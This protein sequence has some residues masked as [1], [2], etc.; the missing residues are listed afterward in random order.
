MRICAVDEV[1]HAGHSIVRLMGADVCKYCGVDSIGTCLSCSSRV[2]NRH[3]ILSV[4]STPSS[5]AT[6]LTYS[7]F[8]DPPLRLQ[9]PVGES[10]V[11]LTVNPIYI[12]AFTHGPP[13]CESCRTQD[14]ERAAS[15]AQQEASDRKVRATSVAQH[16]KEMLANNPDPEA[17]R[18][19]VAQSRNGLA[20]QVS[21]EFVAELR[22]DLRSAW[23]L[24]AASGLWKP[25]HEHVT[26]ELRLRGFR[27]P[28]IAGNEAR[29]VITGREP[30]WSA[31]SDGHLLSSSGDV[32]RLGQQVTV[33]IPRKRPAALIRRAVIRAGDQFQVSDVW[34]PKDSSVYA[35]G[36]L[37]EGA[38][39]LETAWRHAFWSLAD[40]V[41]VTGEL[42]ERLGPRTGRA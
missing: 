17:L 25:T 10:V 6:R 7:P 34:R 8:S 2:C 18:T 9:H 19:F 24:I 22:E 36:Y 4:E 26:A 35:A 42:C 15:E 1:C 5:V 13:R 38:R 12:R 32:W 21:A 3:M 14:G 27:Q 11:H 41:A 30:L 40:E 28:A 33:D 16:L 39:R 29:W 31:A 23:Q 20:D 37:V